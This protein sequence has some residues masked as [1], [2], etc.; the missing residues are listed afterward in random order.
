MKLLGRSRVWQT[1]R[2]QFVSLSFQSVI[3][4]RGYFCWILNSVLAYCPSSFKKS[5]WSEARS[6]KRVSLKVLG[7]EATG[8]TSKQSILMSWLS[9]LYRILEFEHKRFNLR[10]VM[11]SSKSFDY[12]PCL[13]LNL[14][15]PLDSNDVKWN[16]GQENVLFLRAKSNEHGAWSLKWL[17]IRYPGLLSILQW[18]GD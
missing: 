18:M 16:K 17:A 15:L 11:G 6:S 8:I 10:R 14:N 9:S 1:L 2:Q 3:N 4:H 5:H 13:T 12:C 7:V